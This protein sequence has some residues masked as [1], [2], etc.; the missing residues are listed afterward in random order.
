M[1]R[2]LITP[3]HRHHNRDLGREKKHLGG[4]MS[5]GDFEPGVMGNA[6]V[7]NAFVGRHHGGGGGHSRGDRHHGRSPGGAGPGVAGLPPGYQLHVFQ[8]GSSYVAIL[9]KGNQ[10]VGV[11][12]PQPDKTSAANAAKALVPATDQAAAAANTGPGHF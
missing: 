11:T 1:A 5:G 6:F 8:Q 2:E 12:S 7:G 10:L 9:H 4:Y 3:K